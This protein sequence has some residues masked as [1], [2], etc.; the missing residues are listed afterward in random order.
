MNLRTNYLGLSLRSPLVPSSSPLSED[1]D[2]LKR[3]EDAGASAIVFH[4]LFEEQ[5]RQETHAPARYS[6]RLDGVNYSPE[7]GEFH[8][9]PD[10][11]LQNIATAKGTLGIPVIASL[12]GSTFGGWATYAR[13]LERAGADALE[14]NVYAVATDPEVPPDEIEMGYLSMIASVKAQVKI[15]VAVKLS[16]FFTNF[17]HFA[18][19]VDDL[20]VDGLVLFNRFYQPDIDL[21]ALKV[22]PNLNLS[23]PGEIRL[24]LRWIAILHG[25][26]RA[27]LA[28]TSGVHTGADALKLLLAGADVTML[29]SALLRHGPQ[30]LAVVERELR[31][32]M[33]AH[34]L[35]SVEALKGALSQ[36]NCANPTAYERA[37][38]VRT[39]AV[40]R[41]IQPAA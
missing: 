9:A 24:P 29:C 23:S 17:A 14:L 19:R 15:P 3:L 35:T 4:S 22:T 20:G 31:E 38:Y 12:N 32:C 8:H 39:I 27:S 13:A 7:A 41:V 21:D 18:A 10:R 1:L 36:K 5:I 30:Y 28:A 34:G 33:E 26:V 2:N 11:Y 6:G 16:P 37:Q 25:R 40:D